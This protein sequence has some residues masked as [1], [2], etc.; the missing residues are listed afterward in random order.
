MS[1]GKVATGSQTPD[2]NAVK[3]TPYS[4]FVAFCVCLTY[5]VSQLARNVWAT[6]I[7]VAHE[8]LGITM[9]AAGGL[10]TAFYIGYVISNLITGFMV[11]KF[12]P[13]M[14]LALATFFTGLFTALIPFTPYYPALFLLRVGAGIASGPLM[15]GVAKYQISYFSPNTR[16]TAM[17]IMMGGSRLGRIAATALF[18][19]II[20]NI[21]W[22]AG[23][24]YAGIIGVV[25][26]VIFYSFAKEKGAS[27]MRIS[28]HISP[29][30]KAAQ[31]KGLRAVVLNRS[32]IIG[33]LACFL[34]LGAG[35]G[36]N[37]YL[38]IFLTRTR[39]FTLIEA[40]AI[41][42]GTTAIGIV[43][44]PVS[45]MVAD[46]LKSKRKVCIAGAIST[47]VLTALLIV[48]DS[49]VFL[50][51][52]LSLRILL[53]SLLGTPLNSLQAQAAAGPY[54]G[55]AIGIY[56]GFS[57]IGSV[58]FPLLFGFMLDL[59]NM[60]FSFIFIFIT[61]MVAVIGVLIVFMD[62]K[63]SPKKAVAAA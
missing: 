2:L 43:S 57:Q 5:G 35:Q 63:A 11:D 34:N 52:I 37:T 27:A 38:V 3:T 10:M 15:A 50:I 6:A 14:T 61:A 51:V 22:Q 45:G 18:A 28:K 32:F 24:T 47:V 4:W 55:R 16:A 13:R 23:F 7:P 31:S 60:N 30:E 48:A 58:I 54:V 17:A 59:T 26:A 40:G 19:P 25:A 39:G 42:G 8:S 36:F 49:V 12:G 1:D 41:I 62:E 53:Q 44:G 9:A 20:Q 56:N 33:T 46:L 29:E 21:N